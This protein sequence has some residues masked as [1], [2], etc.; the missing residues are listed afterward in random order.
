[1]IFFYLILS[2]TLSTDITVSVGTV[3]D[4]AGSKLLS[5]TFDIIWTKLGAPIYLRVHIIKA[6]LNCNKSMLQIGHEH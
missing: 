5:K 3:W 4:T 6:K 2:I 1:M